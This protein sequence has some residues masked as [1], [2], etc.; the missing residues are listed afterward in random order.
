MNRIHLLNE[1]EGRCAVCKAAFDTDLDRH[2]NTN[3]VVRRDSATG[4][5]IRVFVHRW[6]RPGRKP[7]RRTLDM[8]ADA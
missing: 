8:L 6:C 2:D 5:T 1:Q 4:D 3:V 7:K